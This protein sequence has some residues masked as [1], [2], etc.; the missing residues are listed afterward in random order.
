MDGPLAALVRVRQL[1]RQPVGGA[2]VSSAELR[3]LLTQLVRLHDALVPYAVH[4]A[5]CDSHRLSD[6]EMYGRR[7]PRACSCGLAALVDEKAVLVALRPDGH[8]AERRRG[9]G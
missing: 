5:S 1:L 6:T 7:W 9:R 4:P 3:H 8:G 2:R